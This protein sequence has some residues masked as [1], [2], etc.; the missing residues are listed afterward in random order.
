MSA[1]EFF[2]SGR[3]QGVG[4]RYFVA[5]IARELSISG[6]VRNL[7]DGRVQVHANGSANGLAEFEARLREGPPAAYVHG[8]E[9]QE[10][11]VSN[12][13]WFEIR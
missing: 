11:T 6:W 2:V 8:V 13:D 4:F 10:T 12:A 5:G 1:R 7:S 3:V 9:S